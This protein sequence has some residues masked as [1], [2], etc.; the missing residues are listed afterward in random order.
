MNNFKRYRFVILWC[1]VIF[2][3]SSLT[4]IPTPRDTVLNFLLK[5]SAH[6][7]EYAVLYWLT[8][9]ATNETIGKKKQFLA[10]FLFILFYALTDEFH[11]SFVP[12]RHARSYDL[13]FDAL[14]A[15]LVIQHLKWPRH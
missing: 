2:F 6:L 7:F 10:P 13:V 8:W 1:G 5:K 4:T 11:Q 12:G 3:F 14:G 9:K 15:I